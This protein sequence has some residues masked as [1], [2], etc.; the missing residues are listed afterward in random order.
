VRLVTPP[1]ISIP[2]GTNVDATDFNRADAQS[3]ATDD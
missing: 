2:P 3:N 1:L